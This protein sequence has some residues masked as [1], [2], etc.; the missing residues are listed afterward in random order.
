MHRLVSVVVLALLAACG[1]PRRN[2][3]PAAAGDGSALSAA[4]DA[5]VNALYQVRSAAGGGDYCLG[6]G[7]LLT[8]SVFGWDAMKDQQTRVSATGAVDLPMIGSVPAAGKTESQLRADLERR[9]RDGFMRDPHVTV[10][11]QRFQSQ[12]VSVT[13]AVARPGLYSLTR[14]RRTIYDLLSQ[15]G[16]LTEQAGGRVVF[17]PAT[18]NR[19]GGGTPAPA[20]RLSAGTASSAPRTDTLQPIEFELDAPVTSGH[21]Q[22]LTL[23]VVGGDSIVVSRG[24][25]MVDG[26]VAKP[27]LY[28][29]SPGMTAH[30][31]MTVAGGA[32]FPANLHDA[33]II[34]SHRDGS[35]EI[36]HVDLVSVEQGE[37]RDVALR[38]DD[39]I[40]LNASPARMV[41]YSVYWVFQNL[42]RV[43]AGISVAGV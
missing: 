3:G 16:G 8:V 21:V 24:R 1:P 7:D 35:K 43:G 19:C 33:E 6:P 27:G 28:A 5:R 9:L 20:P 18:E 38:E 22:P 12:Q 29:F 4:D 23:P 14:E 41:P 13:G 30:G 34:R 2:V 32:L 11:V 39:V 15:A 25:F 26:W 42:F 36:L 40:R 31:A 10:F 37:T 17:S